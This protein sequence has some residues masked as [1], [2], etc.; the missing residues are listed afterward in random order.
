MGTTVK[1]NLDAVQ[2][3]LSKRGLQPGGKAQLYMTTEIY[4][5]SIPYTPFD[6]NPLSTLVTIEPNSITYNV[7][8]ARNMY[9]GK[10]MAGNPRKATDK[11]IKYQGSPM[12][13][14][15]WVERAMIDRK[16]D[17]I[18]AVE[19]FIKEGRDI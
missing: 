8:Y 9:Y 11:D 6:N 17:V 18:K 12:R 5:K 1:V 3:I 19:D 4:K 16:Q 7:P 15:L 2:T 13:G 14:K 10:V